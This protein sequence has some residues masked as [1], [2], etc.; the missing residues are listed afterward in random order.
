MQTFIDHTGL[1]GTEPTRLAT[2]LELD[3]ETVAPGDR[4]DLLKRLREGVG[5]RIVTGPLGAP[6]W[7][8]AS[9]EVLV[10][11]EPDGYEY[12]DRHP[13][14]LWALMVQ[15]LTLSEAKTL[16]KSPPKT[17]RHG[18]WDAWWASRS[19][20]DL[21]R[22]GPDVSP[23]RTE[24]YP[25][26]LAAPYEIDNID[27]FC[28]VDWEWDEDTE[29]AVGLA[30]YTPEWNGYVP[31]RGTGSDLHGESA[32]REAFGDLLRRVPT[33]LHNGRSDLR[34]QFLGDPLEL[35]GRVIIHDTLLMG[36]IADPYA[37]DLG[38]KELTR[39]KLGRDPIGYPGNLTHLPV[40]STARYA[41]GDVR[42][43]YDL[44]RVLT[45]ELVATDQYQVYAQL[46]APLVPVVAS[47]EKYGVPVDIAEV[48]RLAYEFGVMEQAMRS[49]VW[50][51]HHRDLASDDDTRKL[52]EEV[53]G[54]DP[55]TLDQRVIS[56]WPDLIIDVI[57][58]FRKCRTTRR[59]YLEKYI[60][61]WYAQGCPTDFRLYP[62]FN[63]A[64]VDN[65]E[66]GQSFGRAPRT[67]RFSSSNPRSGVHAGQGVNIQQQG[68]LFRTIFT[69]PEGCE[70]W[71]L[72]YD[73]LEL[74]IAAA[75]SKDE[76]MLHA[77]R[78]GDKLHRL[79]QE[80]VHQI[81]GV[82][83][84]YEAAKA[85]NFEQLYQGGYETLQRILATQRSPIDDETAKAIVTGHA[86]TFPGYHADADDV[87]ARATL[88]GYSETLRHRRR[89]L[90]DLWAADPNARGHAGRAANN[91]RIQGT[92]ADILKQAMERAVSIL[93]KYG[94]HMSMQVHD[95]LCGWVASDVAKEF[96]EEMRLMMEGIELPGL[97]LKA[98]GGAAK[99]WAEAH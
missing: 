6:F 88:L 64:G 14:M 68:R 66:V 70:F 41:C 65:D 73:G 97:S 74:H 37:D 59:N 72:D 54:Y 90:P 84:E 8:L 96:I 69:A 10:A 47:M 5:V 27:E 49:Y 78:V 99:T 71:S 31:V 51:R 15:G 33:V 55:G 56:K 62:N 26:Q 61:K 22:G 36:Y 44:F 17:K 18:K 29:Q 60:E 98:S 19:L 9:K 80:R 77:L 83:I 52:I 57:L 63:Q 87:V 34:S 48:A 21:L 76:T 53:I 30:V 50:Q 20:L 38:L 85:G 4:L 3:G 94:A 25:W 81:T 45:Q 24:E 93:R 28:A 40:E 35:A 79:F 58:G 95:E 92:A 67:G 32:T 89:Y 11:V 23:I 1:S 82:P 16:T 7:S 91:H 43:T 75:M 2:L 46:E 13:P 12:T 39:K 42:N 86:Q